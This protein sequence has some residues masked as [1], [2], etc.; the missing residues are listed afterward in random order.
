[1]KKLNVIIVIT[2]VSF[3]SYGQNLIIN[4]SFDDLNKTV[5]NPK[6]Y[7]HTPESNHWIIIE[8]L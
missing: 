1:M 3:T 8:K 6:G 7:C 4:S 5:P 2:L